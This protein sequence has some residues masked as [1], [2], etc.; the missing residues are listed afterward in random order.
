[1]TPSRRRVQEPEREA[2]GR[3]QRGGE[4]AATV[5]YRIRGL[6]ANGGATA[7]KVKPDA[8]AGLRRGEVH[9]PPASAT[10]R[11]AEGEDHHHQEH[12]GEEHYHKQS[13]KEHGDQERASLQPS[14]HTLLYALLHATSVNTT[15]LTPPYAV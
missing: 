13:H 6:D 3:V 1:M 2:F 12:E 4:R 11:H 10:S 9:R 15:A 7:S 5:R 8:A 14:S